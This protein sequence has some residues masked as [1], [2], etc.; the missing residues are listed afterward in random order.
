[1]AVEPTKQELDKLDAKIKELTKRS[2]AAHDAAHDLH[3]T[4]EAA[5]SLASAGSK[6]LDELNKKGAAA[7]KDAAR[8]RT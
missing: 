1:M 8:R 2:D 6:E 4:A 5:K 7:D 3:T